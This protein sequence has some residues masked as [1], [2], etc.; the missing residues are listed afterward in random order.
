LGVMGFISYRTEQSEVYRN[1]VKR[2]YIA[3]A[4][5][6]YRKV[7]KRGRF[8]YKPD[9]F[10][11]SILYKSFGLYHHKNLPTAEPCRSQAND[12]I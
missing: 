7:K 3:F 10:S 5:R 12:R 11:L 8:G 4:Q 9:L 2:G 1:R 6:I